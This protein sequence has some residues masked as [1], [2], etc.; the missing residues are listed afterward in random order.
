MI[1][2]TQRETK[3]SLAA[4]ERYD[5][6][7]RAWR[8]KRNADISEVLRRDGFRIAEP[9]EKGQDWPVV[10]PDGNGDFEVVHLRVTVDKPKRKARSKK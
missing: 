1:A 9:N 6:N 10:I 3:T 5:A 8:E 7:L 4:G 2:K